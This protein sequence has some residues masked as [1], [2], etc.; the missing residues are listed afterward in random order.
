MQMTG[1][2]TI[3]VVKSQEMLEAMNLQRNVEI[4]N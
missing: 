4:P 3:I 2:V 1:Q